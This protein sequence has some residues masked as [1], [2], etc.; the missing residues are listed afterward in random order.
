MKLPPLLENRVSSRFQPFEILIKGLSGINDFSL[1]FSGDSHRH[2][3]TPSLDT[4]FP[5][6]GRFD[7][8]IPFGLRS[9]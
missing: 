6:C 4:S 7:P 9:V 2:S 8:Q 5:I 3:P 1:V